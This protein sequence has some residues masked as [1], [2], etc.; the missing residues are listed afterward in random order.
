MTDRPRI[1][2]DSPDARDRPA[3]S[4]HPVTPE[5]TRAPSNGRR[6]SPRTRE[7]AEDAYV[8]ARNAWVT[9]MR[10][11]NSGRSADLA[12]LA[13]AQE[14]YE[15][16]AAERERW[17]SGGRVA[18]PIDPTPHGG[19]DLSAVVGQ[20][21]AWREVRNHADEPRGFWRL[22]RRRRSED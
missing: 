14:A 7:E 19:A 1:R 9:A 8:A 22:F 11:A 16:A 13:I 12:A 2:T 3:A 10:Q 21:L 4:G 17:L 18:I 5:R 6:L 20:E 15:L